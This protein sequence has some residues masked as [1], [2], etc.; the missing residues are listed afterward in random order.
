MKVFILAKGRTRW[1]S[2]LLI[3]A[4]AIQQGK[5]VR[6]GLIEKSFLFNLARIQEY[7]PDWIFITGARTF[8][9]VQLRAFAKV[10]KLV[11]WDADGIH[12]RT[13]RYWDALRGIPDV[14]ISSSIGKAKHLVDYA[15]KVVFIPQFWDSVYQKVT[16]IPE[17]KHDV[18]F[19]G[20]SDFS[21]RRKNWLLN[22][23]EELSISS[24]GRIPN[25]TA[26]CAYGTNMANAYAAHRISFDIQREYVTPMECGTSD[27]M[28]KA[29]GCGVLY[30]TY[31]IKGIERL[32][33][34]GKHFVEY[35][36]TYDDLVNKIK[37]YLEHKEEREKIAVEGQKEVLK[38]HTLK[39]RLNQYWEVMEL[40]N[41]EH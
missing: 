8:T 19:I 38:A 30:I 14:I 17:I 22:L 9:P 5:D 2:G 36:G 21:Q 16:V 32:F 40:F 3:Y 33:T 35:D 28:F 31:P 18:I 1:Q 4:E 41:Q 24:R 6:L 29:M 23:N 11:I 15:H 37:Y 25:L 27:R 39:T 34:P 20:S 10:A 26:K 13:Q 12:Q 7:S